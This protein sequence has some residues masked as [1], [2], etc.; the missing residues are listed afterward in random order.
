MRLPNAYVFMIARMCAS[1]CMSRCV[2]LHVCT[3]GSLTVEADA[4]LGRETDVCGP[5]QEYKLIRLVM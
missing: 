1:T 2:F 4:E 3:D 5:P